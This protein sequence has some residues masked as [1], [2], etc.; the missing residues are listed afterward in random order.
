M[1]LPN[2]ITVLRIAIVP[3]FFTE[4]VTYR[5]GHEHH[6]RTALILFI[7]AVFTDALDGFIARV[8]K[9]K[10]E[11]GTF[12]DP[13]ADKLLLVSAFLG[14]LA[15]DSLPFRPPLWITVTIVFRDLMI[16]VGLVIIY[17]ISGKVKVQPNFLGKATTAIQ[18]I[19]FIAILFKWPHSFVLWNFS[20]ALTITSL[21]VYCR[22]ELSKL[23]SPL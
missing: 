15:V 8:T 1:N 22:R 23:A 7:A 18:M 19:T 3:F 17:L 12:L 20:A 5:P 4:L 6:L 10:T 9:T 11:L 16:I 14:L 2:Y 13:L 21:W